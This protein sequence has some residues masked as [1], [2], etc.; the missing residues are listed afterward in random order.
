M[1]TSYEI[2][3]LNAAEYASL[4]FNAVIQQHTEN[5]IIGILE[6]QFRKGDRIFVYDASELSSSYYKPIV[7]NLRKRLAV[8]SI[9][10]DNKRIYVDW[11]L[12][13]PSVVDFI[14]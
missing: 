1:L 2:Q 12:P 6:T 14:V 9:Y 8:S 7:E 11:S 4:C 10:I 5:I 3:N 13:P